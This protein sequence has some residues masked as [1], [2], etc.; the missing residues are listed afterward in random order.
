MTNIYAISMKLYSGKGKAFPEFIM[1]DGKSFAINADFRN[2]LRIFAMIK[3]KHI[4]DIRKA[5][6]LCGWFIESDEFTEI[7][8]AMQAFISFVGGASES[9]GE[10]SLMRDE[11][12][13]CYEFDG[14]EIY[15]SFLCEY[16]IDLIE[17][18]YLHWYKFRILLENLPDTSAFNKK[19]AVRFL[20]LNK[21]SS[22]EPGFSD[23]LKAWQS[24]QLPFDYSEE[25]TYEMREFEEF[26]ERVK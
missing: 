18:G 17:C 25:E 16:D 21:F 1:L 19:L 23:I 13:F 26:W 22:E 14:E 24:V 9:A 6:K 7:A 8:K 3:D 10:C 5:C 11:P 20:D 2:I 15:A 12:Q 4:P